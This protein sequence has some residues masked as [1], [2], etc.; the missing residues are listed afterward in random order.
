MNEQKKYLNQT[1]PQHVSVTFDPGKE[2]KEQIIARQD[3][4]IKLPTIIKD[5]LGDF[6]TGEKIK[7]I[8]NYFKLN[9]MQAGSIARAIRNY[10]FGDI[11]LEDFPR[12]FISEMKVDEATAQKISQM[13][14][15][16]IVR[17][18]SFEKAYI[19]QIEKAPFNEALRKYSAF[20]EQLVTTERIKISSFPEPVRPSV[21]NWIADYTAMPDYD[22]NNPDSMK[23]QNYIFRS[24]NAKNLTANNKERLSFVLRS[25]DE[26]GEVAFN[27]DTK[28]L[29]FEEIRENQTI[30][31]INSSS[32]SFAPISPKKETESTPEGEL[33]FSF[34]QKMPFEKNSEP[35]SP[36]P[37][38]SPSTLN[39]SFSKQEIPP[40]TVSN[41]VKIPPKVTPPPKNVVN[42]KE[43]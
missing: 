6:K 38:I 36:A 15:Q 7:G 29:F 37:P 24:P 26:N 39:S 10:Y 2:T 22:R 31:K 12:I 13:A 23:R 17:D 20:G 18:D 33:H 27:K 1:I 28:V 42:L 30:P 5:K 32:V 40:K 34:P 11:K 41:V 16:Q 14:I 19:A 3:R 35:V 9:E 25:F 4:F 21:K 43:L 8:G